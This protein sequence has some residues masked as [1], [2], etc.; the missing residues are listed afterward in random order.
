MPYNPLTGEFEEEQLPSAQEITGALQQQ[1]S[2]EPIARL[3]SIMDQYRQ[4]ASSPMQE[5][6]KELNQVLA[7][8]R[9]QLQALA[10]AKSASQIGAGIA[11]L[12]AGS[13]IQ[14]NLESF[15]P[16]E[17]LAQAGIEE[18]KEKRASKKEKL[19]ERKQSLSEQMGLTESEMKLQKVEREAM[20]DK[21]LDDS[22]SAT[23]QFY[24][25]IAR[26]QYPKINIPD[27]LSARHIIKLKL[28]PQSGEGK[29]TF[30]QAPVID[31]TTG[32]QQLYKFDT[33][34]GEATPV[35]GLSKAY[36]AQTRIDPYT[37]KLIAI[38]PGA[39]E[40]SPI[41]IGSGEKIPTEK[42][43]IV[44]QDLNPEQRKELKDVEKEYRADIKDSVEFGETLNGLND[45]ISADIPAAIPVIRRQL[46]RSV[47]REVGVMTD[48]DV[49]Q[50][51]GDP[52][53]LAALERFAKMQATG[54][55]T[56]RDKQ[57]YQQIMEMA[58]NNLRKSI[59]NRAS[60][61][62]TR[63]SQR[64]PEAT[65]TSLRNI[66]AVE[67]SKPSG[68]Q[69]EQDVLDY[70]EKHNISPEQ[71]QRIKEMRMKKPEKK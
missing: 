56:E 67:Q 26:Q 55:M 65:D 30:Q 22:E 57:Q 54:K 8:R 16:V 23:S 41:Q 44:F 2:N 50:F 6:D 29:G 52:S 42:R 34:T 66:L 64:V 31:P 18:L 7:D 25:Q 5:E 1:P 40:K 14:A 17:Q 11:G 68:V 49:S 37:G 48:R 21:E 24:R 39:P 3:R 47:G 36:A 27:T 33:R 60:Y 71:A 20:L 51:S 9:S 70:A 32:H 63:L 62:V 53:F 59:D 10:L 35:G 19:A 43:D 61:H 12:G 15:K 58:Q 38:Q 4:L 69:Y 46:A 45:L 28:G 13:N